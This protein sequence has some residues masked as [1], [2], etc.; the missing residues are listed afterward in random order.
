MPTCPG[1]GGVSSLK[2][3]GQDV[4]SAILGNFQHVYTYHIVYVYTDDVVFAV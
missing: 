2:A 1:I 3:Y 4:I